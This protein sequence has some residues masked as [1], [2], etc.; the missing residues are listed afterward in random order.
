MKLTILV[1]AL[2][3]TA[4]AGNAM[5]QEPAPAKPPVHIPADAKFFKGKWY[6]IYVEKASWRRAKEKCRSLKG[7]LAIV[8]DKETWEFIK[9]LS[10]AS[11]WLGATDEKAEGDWRWVDGSSVKFF[12]WIRD[13]PNNANGKEHYVAMTTYRGQQGWNDFDMEGTASVLTVNGFICEWEV[14]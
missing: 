4:V 12:D 6:R 1:L 9:G 7:Q 10:K 11:L 5:A 8:R 3:F 2:F 14:K 13:N